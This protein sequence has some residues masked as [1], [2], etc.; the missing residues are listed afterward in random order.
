M[1]QNKKYYYLINLSYFGNA[2]FGWQKQKNFPTL[3]GT[4]ET[5]LEK[6]F[7]PGSF[8]LLGASRTDSKVHALDQFC[9]LQLNESIDERELKDFLNKKLPSDIH[10]KQ[11]IK[12]NAQFRLIQSVKSKCY[13]YYFSNQQSDNLFSSQLCPN[14]KE[15]L[16]IEAMIEALELFKGVHSFHNYQYRS[17]IKGTMEREIKALSIE[18]NPHFIDGLSIEQSYLIKIEAN[19]FMKQM[20]RLIVGTLI[21]LG[22]GLITKE[23]IR[24][25]LSLKSNLKLGFIAP[26]SG[27]YLCSIHF[28]N[29]NL[30]NIFKR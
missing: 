12:S 26:G 2:Y 4:I 17:P 7:G 25:S 30:E 8:H 5:V 3:S 21:D 15:Q 27:L 19:G 28:K 20:V 23:Q 16:D 6:R 9:K 13:C 22:R 10:I 14:F 24:E 11:I 1:E 29:E 18:K